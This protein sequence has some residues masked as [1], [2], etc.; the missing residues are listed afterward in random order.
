MGL[1]RAKAHEHWHQQELRTKCV[2][3]E[4]QCV[5]YGIA[6]GLEIEWLQD[7]TTIS[8]LEVGWREGAKESR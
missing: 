3:W 5:H 4:T 8:Q 1:R 6:V 2:H 7:F